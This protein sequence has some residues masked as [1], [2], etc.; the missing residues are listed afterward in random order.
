[1]KAKLTRS[2]VTAVSLA[3]LLTSLSGIKAEAQT[4]STDTSTKPATSQS[5]EG[6]RLGRYKI[7]TYGAVGNRLF[8]GYLDLLAGGV[9]KASN[10]G[11]NGYIGQGTYS[12]GSGSVT[13]NN[14]PYTT[15]GWSGTFT[16][17]REGKTHKIRLKS[18]TIAT[19][20]TDS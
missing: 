7:Y 19:N 20:S 10:P 14:G 12:F 1:M 3:L 18:N 9:Y 4:P 11:A 2:T 6:P 13:W 16:V 8:L 15:S 5:T 17:E